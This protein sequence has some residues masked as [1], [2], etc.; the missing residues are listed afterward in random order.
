M[1]R[2]ALFEKSPVWTAIAKLS[3][4]ALIS[5]LVMLLYNMTDMYFVGQM[6]DY[7][8]VA[9]VSLVTPA[10]TVL[11]AISTMI[12]NG[13]C[14]RIAQ[15][16]GAGERDRAGRCVAVCVWACIAFGALF[17]ALCWI[18]EGPVLRLLGANE[19][20]WDG[21]RAYLLIIA[22]GAPVILLNHTLGGVVRGEGVA[23]EGMLGGLVATVVN[24]ALDPLFIGTFR[25]GVGGA[26]LATVIGNAAGIAYYIVYK[27]KRE[28]LLTFS[29]RAAMGGLALLGGVLALGMPN[30]ISSTLS[31]FAGTLG[32]RLLTGY[33]T[34]AVAAS[35]A[36]SRVTMIITM[37]QM[38]V[39]MGAQPLMAYCYGAGNRARLKETI[40]K[41]LILNLALGAVLGAGA[42][43][44]REPIVRLFITEDTVVAVACRFV[45]ITV[46]TA[47][48]MG[49]FYPGMNTLQATGHALAATIVSALRQGVLLIAF[50]H[51]MEALLGLIGIPAAHVVADALAIVISVSTAIVSLRG[52]GKE[53]SHGR[54]A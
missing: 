18:F 25:M 42:I 45:S 13:G 38:G 15:L 6:G 44:L 14:T 7:T 16:F 22:A 43:L 34:E 3:I 31:G 37:V 10:Y 1:N 20:M 2:E 23:K 39:C 50:L 41:L 12:G 21:A 49:L 40:S 11:M 36:A 27:R 47:P 9:A 8:Q 33:G 54:R 52:K 19:E 51:V 30:A 24:I 17:A 32:N 46:I 4:P 5:I 28:T 35:A 29:P 48:L 26:A 53:E